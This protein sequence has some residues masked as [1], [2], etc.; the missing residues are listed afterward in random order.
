MNTLLTNP[1]FDEIRRLHDNQESGSLLLTNQGGQ[2]IDVFFREGL[3]QAV[4]ST[5]ETLRLGDYLAKEGYVTA[6]ALDAVE[7]VARR[8]KIVLGE[9]AV[10]KGLL[11]QVEVAS[12]ARRQAIELLDYAFKN[13]FVVDSF[14][15]HLRSYFAPARISYPNV[16]LELCRSNAV[17]FESDPNT[18]IALS[19]GANPS[20]FQWHPQE[21]Y[22]L[23]ELQYP[24]TFEHLLKATS[25]QQKALKKILGVLGA[26]G[27]IEAHKASDSAAGRT[28]SN[29]LIT[30]SEFPFEHLIP[31]VTNAVLNEKLEVAKNELSFTSEQFK[32]L[33]VLIAEANSAAPLK[34]LTVSSPDAQDGK[35]L[36]ASNLAFSFAMDPGRRV[37]IV[38]CDLRKPSLGDYLGVTSEPGL[39]QYLANGH[40]SP[41]C[42]VRRLQNLYFMTT[43]G[44]APNPVEVLSMRKMKQLIERLKKD[45]DTVILDAPPYCPI[46]DARIVTGMSDGLVIVV[47][48]GKTSYGSAD[49]A[50]K[51]I[52][53][54]KLLGVVFNDVQPMLFHTYYNFGYYQYGNQKVYSAAPRIKQAPKNYLES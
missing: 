32:N 41:Y 37:I 27:V 14:E 34:V 23:S 52:D 50:F 31:V 1:V 2:R 39:L 38:D 25:L 33:K 6:Q 40:L 35:S 49:R 5:F 8:Q 9:A 17:P 7:P 26:L 11:N 10:R 51:A 54:N 29:A 13:G 43:G 3:I 47:R 15:T 53:R 30:T 42:Y 46:S 48:R 21:M 19:E 20:L 18:T 16:M 4:S 36:V 44:V 24:N 45:F 12:A 22:V 28:G